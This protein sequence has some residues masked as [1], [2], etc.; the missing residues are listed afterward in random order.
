MNKKTYSYTMPTTTKVLKSTLAKKIL[1]YNIRKLEYKPYVDIGIVEDNVEYL[2]KDKGVN[3]AY[4]KE[5]LASIK[6]RNGEQII[7]NDLAHFKKKG[8]AS[9]FILGFMQNDSSLP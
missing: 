1:Y 4:R 6:K 7:Y 5:A 2:L 8:I 9:K 3:G